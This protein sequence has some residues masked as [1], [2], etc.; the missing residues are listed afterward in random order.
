MRR[1][2]ALTLPVQLEQKTFEKGSACGLGS[3]GG[4]GLRGLQ[5]SGLCWASSSGPGRSF[6]RTSSQAS[7]LRLQGL[8]GSLR[9][10]KLLV[11]STQARLV[12]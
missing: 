1:S 2:E 7:E 3:R 6:R 9:V 8:K 10:W 5:G 11:P 4:R 12:R